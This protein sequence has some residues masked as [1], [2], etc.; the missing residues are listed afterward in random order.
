VTPPV[1]T[2]PAPTVKRQYPH[3]DTIADWR[4]QQSIRLLWDRIFDL[5][6]RLQGLGATQGDLVSAVNTLETQLTTVAYTAGEALALAQITQ[7]EDGAGGGEGPDTMPDYASFVDTALAK[8]VSPVVALADGDAGKAQLTRQV[9]W[10]IYQVDPNIRL[11]QKT[12]GAQVYGMSTDL[13]VQGTD[14][15]FADVTTF[16]DTID[17]TTIETTWITH[18]PDI[19]TS[20]SGRWIVPTEAIAMMAG[21]MVR[22]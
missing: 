10:D 6:A 14:G 2:T 13:V 22:I 5:E 16:D 15:S 20:D 8:F 4:A 1:E 21:P 12:G 18:G 3:V 11:F 17:P 9:A 19:R 7:N